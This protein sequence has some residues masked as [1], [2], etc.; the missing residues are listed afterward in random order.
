[1]LYVLCY[2]SKL[3]Q[4]MILNSLNPITEHTLIKE[5]AGVRAAKSC[6]SHLLNM[7]QYIEDGYKKSLTTGAVFVDLY[8]AYDT[9]NHRLILTKL[10]GMIKDAGFTKLI[11]SVMSNQWFYV[12]LNGNKNR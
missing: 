11:G 5:Q 9:V 2:P 12:E 1:M 6:T 10:Y 7:T 8:A 4:R 3:F